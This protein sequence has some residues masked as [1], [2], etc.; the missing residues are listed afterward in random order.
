MILV[1]VEREII[2]KIVLEFMMEMVVLIPLLL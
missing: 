2:W 1:T